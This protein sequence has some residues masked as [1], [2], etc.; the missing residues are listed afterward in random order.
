M[1]PAAQEVAQRDSQGTLGPLD[2]RDLAPTDLERVAVG[3]SQDDQA[4]TVLMRLLRGAGVPG[5]AAIA[6]RL[7]SARQYAR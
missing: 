7:A 6:L 3:H 5:L 1:D 2:G 4:E